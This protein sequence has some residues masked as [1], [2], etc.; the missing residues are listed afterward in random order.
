ML[1]ERRAAG[2]SAFL[3][4]T[5]DLKRP[6]GLSGL[7]AGQPGERLE[8]GAALYWQG[9]QAAD[10]FAV[11]EG[12]LRM[13]RVLGDGRRVI[14][15]FLFVGDLAG[16]SA[17]TLYP[18]SAEA[19][20]PTRVRRFDR[21]RLNAEMEDHPDLQRQFFGQLS[22]EMKAARDQVVLL[23]LKTAEERVTSFLL[24]M[25]RRTGGA[26]PATVVHL[27]MARLDIADYLGLTVETVSRTMSRLREM[28]VIAQVSR[29]T[30]IVRQPGRLAVLAADD[31]S[32]EDHER[33]LCA[34]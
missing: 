16:A 2:E 23:A 26:A 1:L 29:H 15:G 33:L 34:S 14:T 30:I 13:T 24:S 8:S 17:A 3:P 9:D 7:F 18:D 19:I 10:V 32:D 25:M 22:R 27:P 11:V 21:R 6:Q 4:Q 5:G 28:G 31:G 12:G 20:G